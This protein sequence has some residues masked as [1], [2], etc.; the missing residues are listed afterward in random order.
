MLTA[1]I[2][3]LIREPVIGIFWQSII[4]ERLDQRIMIVNTHRTANDFTDARDQN[5]GGFRNARI[6]RVRL[7]IE[8]LDGT[9]KV[10]ENDGF[11]N[12]ID[13][14]PLRSLLNIHTESMN[15]AFFVESLF[16]A[17][18]SFFSKPLDRLLISH[19]SERSY[20]Q[21]EILGEYV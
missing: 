5:I 13:H 6:F 14:V 7:H 12:G 2:L 1:A 20:C 9:R 8:S 3:P 17:L 18:S 21:P 11:A 15:L 4:L 10:G 16:L 19:P